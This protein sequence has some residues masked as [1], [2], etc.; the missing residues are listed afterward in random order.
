M[1]TIT[2]ISSVG[3]P[4]VMCLLIFYQSSKTIRANTEAIRELTLMLKGR[5]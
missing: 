1:D 3:F 2:A 4:I 5:K